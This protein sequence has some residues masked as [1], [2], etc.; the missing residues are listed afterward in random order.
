MASTQLGRKADDAAVKALRREV[1]ALSKAVAGCDAA[2]TGF[3]SK[4]RTLESSVGTAL[5]A[6][7]PAAQSSST[8]RV[9]HDASGDVAVDSSCAPL[10]RLRAYGST[11]CAAH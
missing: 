7:A 2:Q 6:A 3:G 9:S 11:Q 8:L 4:L 10:P 5:P 1:A